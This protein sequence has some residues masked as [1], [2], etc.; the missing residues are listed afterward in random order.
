[1]FVRIASTSTSQYFYIFI[2]VRYPR[3]VRF[4]MVHTVVGSCHSVVASIQL[5]SLGVL[6]YGGS[7]CTR[8]CCVCRISSSMVSAWHLGVRKRVIII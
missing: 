5:S 1:M 3:S 6:L 4:I 8:L 7:T 2:E